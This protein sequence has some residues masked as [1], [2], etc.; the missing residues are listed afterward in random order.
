MIV[1]LALVQG[2]SSKRWKVVG[3]KSEE[4]EAYGYTCTIY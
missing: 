4:C 1:V 3:T 2:L